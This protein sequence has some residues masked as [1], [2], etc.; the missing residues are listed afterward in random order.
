MNSLEISD[1]VK[2]IDVVVLERFSKDR[3][4]GKTAEKQKHF[5]FLR[6][7]YEIKHKLMK[8][9]KKKRQNLLERL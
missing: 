4:A 1:H 2:S 8:K 6:Q 7:D 9:K 5:L 3:I